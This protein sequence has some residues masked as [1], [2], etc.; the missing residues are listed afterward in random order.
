VCDLVWV[1][2]VDG[3]L[4][5]VGL[6]STVVCVR[7]VTVCWV[8]NILSREKSTINIHLMAMTVAGAIGWRQ[9]VNTTRAVD[10]E[11]SPEPPR[12][13]P[14]IQRLSYVPPLF[15]RERLS[16]YGAREPSIA[17]YTYKSYA[18]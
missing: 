11:G 17:K 4:A 6:C 16:S 18:A 12:P 15:I 8:V 3:C 7:V 9:T 1:R 2:P 10:G 13:P 5:P 14:T